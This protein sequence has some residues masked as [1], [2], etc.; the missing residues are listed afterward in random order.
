MIDVTVWSA[1]S[2][3]LVAWRLEFRTIGFD[4]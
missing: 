1:N 3:S 2:W 4:N